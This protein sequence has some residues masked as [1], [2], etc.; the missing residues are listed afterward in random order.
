ME[1]AGR[2][3]HFGG[4]TA[5]VTKLFNI[6]GPCRSYFGEKDFQQ[7]AVVR[8]MVADLDQPVVIVGCPI[9]REND[10]LAMSSRN[11]YLSSTEREAAT[12]INRALRAGAA[13]IE[14]GEGDPSV[15]ESH[16]ASIIDAEPLAL[17]DYAAVVNPE[18]LL[19]PDRLVS[20]TT[21]RLLMVAQ[22]GTPRLLDNLG[23]DV[24]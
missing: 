16:M 4:V 21:V 7:L 6:A 3:T 24:P 14:A 20:G 2:P 8:R 9:V 13:M 23:V 11:V 17:L 22:M 18:S 1:G 10:G 15:V 19:T 12:V 5:V